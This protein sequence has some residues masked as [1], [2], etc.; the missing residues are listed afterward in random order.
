MIR[1]EKCMFQD[2][3]LCS[4]FLTF[5]LVKQKQ[6]CYEYD[7]YVL[8]KNK[9][10]MKPVRAEPITDCFLKYLSFM[11]YLTNIS[12]IWRNLKR[13]ESVTV[14]YVTVLNNVTSEN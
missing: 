4:K 9:I 13:E 14:K 11:M 8:L 6:W 12:N 7:K 1:N 3:F 10:L 5:L 2:N